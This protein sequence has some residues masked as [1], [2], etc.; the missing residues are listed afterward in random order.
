MPK[1]DVDDRGV[2]VEEPAAG[3]GLLHRRAFLRG[4]ALFSGAA[5]G[6]TLAQLSAA[7][8]EFPP[9]R[10]HPGRPFV[11]YGSPSQFERHVLRLL[12]QRPPGH[13]TP[14]AGASFTPLEMLQGMITPSGLHYERSHNGV[15]DI[16]PARHELIIHGMVRRPL[17]FTMDALVRYPMRAR[18]SISSSAPATASGGMGGVRR[19]PAAAEG[20]HGLL[21][22]AEWTGDLAGAAARTKPAWI[23]EL[24]GC[25][26]KASTHR[27]MSRSVPLAKCMDDALLA[28]YQNG[29]RIRPEQGYPLRL[30]LPGYE[31]NMSVKWL[32]R[33]KVTKGPTHTKDETSKYTDLLPDGRA[34]QFTF[35]MDVKS[36]ITRPATGLTMQGA[37]LYEVSG[38]AWSGAGR[39]RS[40]RGVRRRREHVGARRRCRSRS[41]AQALTRFRLPWQ[42]NGGPA[43]LQSRAVDER[44]NVQPTRDALMS[45][46]GT[47]SVNH[48]NGIT[49]CYVDKDGQVASAW[50]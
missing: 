1:S 15:P 30:F 2:N 25:S 11:A 14:G 48:Y 39:D 18:T 35:Q 36:T 37:G 28:I 20:M 8:A 23:F 5:F 16:D 45:E 46:R 17:V 31:G 7:A 10:T 6:G 43:I 22:C 41:C 12:P 49:R 29:E 42:W 38:L 27:A 4:G 13:P 34:L 40:C 32:H 26:P 50:T 21:S 19:R 33:I 24:I 9:W 3:N 47:N 44:G